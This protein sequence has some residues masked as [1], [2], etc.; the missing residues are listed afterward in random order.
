MIHSARASYLLPFKTFDLEFGSRLNL[1]TGNNGLGKTYLLQLLWQ[2]LSGELTNPSTW[3]PRQG[4]EDPHFELSRDLP[5]RAGSE[6]RK[7]SYN[8]SS[9]DQRWAV[10]Q[11]DSSEVSLPDD[12]G[13]VGPAIY[14]KIDGSFSAYDYPRHGPG[15]VSLS[16]TE[17]W[18]GLKEGDKYVCN[19]L[20][21]DL[22]TWQFNHKETFESLKLALQ[23]LSDN[24][25]P[26]ELGPPSRFD[27]EDAREMPSLKMPYGEIPITLASAG[28]QRILTIA[29]FLVWTRH[30]HVTACKLR[31][32]PPSDHLTILLDEVELHLHP[33]WQ[34]LLMPALLKTVEQ[35]IGDGVKLQIF[36][37]THSSLVTASLEPHFDESRDALFHCQ[38][39]S[40]TGLVKIDKLPWHAMGEADAWLTSEVFGLKEP[41]SL[42]AEQA[43]LEARKTFSDPNVSQEQIRE[44]HHRLRDTLGELDPFWARWVYF[45]EKKGIAV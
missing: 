35:L 10:E 4:Q 1:I 45:A 15:P 30:E 39:D 12:F 2:E 36:A 38:Q 29:Y 18:G 26:L 5:Y 9:K 28:M 27:P 19:G 25:E 44:A 34:R 33:S 31:K 6:R 37:T 11:D 23:T 32:I 7:C 42:P 40:T 14:I 3:V 16:P 21:S 17:L 24:A 22:V 20:I 41:R 8:Y 43:I 13:P